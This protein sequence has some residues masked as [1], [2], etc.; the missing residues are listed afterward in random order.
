MEYRIV[1]RPNT[2]LINVV[3]KDMLVKSSNY[4]DSFE[5]YGSIY[6]SQDNYNSNYNEG[7]SDGYDNAT[8]NILDGVQ[9]GGAWV[10]CYVSAEVW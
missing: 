4:P 9:V 1:V 10:L 8:Q 2:S 7:Y 6:Y 3:F 5:P